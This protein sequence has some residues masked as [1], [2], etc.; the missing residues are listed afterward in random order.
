MGYWDIK[1]ERYS[2]YS[3]AER[4]QYAQEQKEAARQ[5]IMKEWITVWRLKEDRNWTDAAIQK[6]LGEPKKQNGYS[7]FRVATVYEAEKTESFQSWMLKRVA[8]QY[9]NNEELFGTEYAEAVLKVT[10]DRI[11]KQR[12]DVET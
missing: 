8:K 1:R 11:G 4:R 10:L 6:H 3:D 7:V 5:E 9:P 12:S 2:P